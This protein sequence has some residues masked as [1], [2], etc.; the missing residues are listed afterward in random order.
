MP[1][2]KLPDILRQQ[3][4][5]ESGTINNTDGP[6]VAVYWYK[7]VRGDIYVGLELDGF[8]LYQNLSSIDHEIN[9]QYHLSP[10]VSCKSDDLDFNPDE[11][12]IISINVSRRS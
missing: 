3:L 1:P 8:K 6:G 2:V 10:I 9:M 4:E 7:N 11:D 12:K 5:N